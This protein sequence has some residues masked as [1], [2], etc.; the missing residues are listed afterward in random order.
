MQNIGV[1]CASPRIVSDCNCFSLCRLRGQYP[2]SES[3]SPTLMQMH[4][5]YSPPQDLINTSL[6]HAF[7]IHQFDINL[8]HLLP[9]GQPISTKAHPQLAKGGYTLGGIRKR[10]RGARQ[11]RRCTEYNGVH[12]FECV[13][14]T[15]RGRCHCEYF[16]AFGKIK[17]QHGQSTRMHQPLL[18]QYNSDALVRD[19]LLKNERYA[20]D[21]RKIADQLQLQDDRDKLNRQ[22]GALQ[23]ELDTLNQSKIATDE[24]Q[25]QLQKDRD[26]LNRQ[27]GALKDERDTLDK[28][29]IAID[30]KQQN[31]SMKEQAIHRDRDE[32][33]I[34]I[35]LL[36]KCIKNKSHQ[37]ELR[38]KSVLDMND[39]TKRLCSELMKTSAELIE[40]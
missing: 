8:C 11:C 39:M 32:L 28:R 34:V 2:V 7:N 15:R 19:T 17:S 22:K 40:A 29:K 30:E 25:L 18:N 31:L 14:R 24:D 27:K 36:S 23:I 13:G 6:C 21:Q 20:L 37:T 4:L 38:L 16:D 35:K 10:P 9:G 1:S 5:P 26:K 33:A 3:E 12:S